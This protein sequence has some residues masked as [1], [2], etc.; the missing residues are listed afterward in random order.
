[1]AWTDTPLS[2]LAIFTSG[3]TPRKSVQ[4]YWDGDIPW[5]SASSMGKIR[6]TDSDRKLTRLGAANGTRIARA[7]TTLI[8][9]RGMSLLEE[10]RV[11]SPVRD[12]AFNQD[13]KALTALPTIDPQFLTYALL[14]K[15]PEL[16]SMVHLAGHGTGVLSTD[17]LKALRIR[18]PGIREQRR[19]A[20]VLGV[21]DD[22]I[23]TDLSLATAADACA[24]AQWHRLN[25]QSTAQAELAS[26]ADVVLGGTP[27]RADPTMWGGEIPWINSGE[28]N[29]F[30][31]LHPTERITQK[32]LER[33][34]TKLMPEGTTIVAITGATLGQVSR[35]EI[36]ACGNQS[37]V[38]VYCRQ[39][40]ALNDHL[41]FTVRNSV[42]KLIASATGG[43]QQHIN[44]RNVEELLLSVPDQ[45]ALQDW[46]RTT[47]PLLDATSQLLMEADRLAQTRDELL[48]L[49][50]SG[51][52][53]VDEA[54]EA[55]PG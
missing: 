49:L 30:R 10:I 16:L 20:G 24:E 40:P 12:V 4:D 39:N 23:D 6:I 54:W 50:M 46:H 3:G 52:I 29:K 19:I 41:Y 9:V 22:L 36:P 25:S 2:E 37:L 47:G 28:A 18:H 45:P 27:S 43:A 51:R 44:K 48:P 15:R 1:M 17:R 7:G 42:Q 55:V 33:S 5:I 38:G 34:S 14:A 21:F 35:L 11:G 8:L 32:G 26:L 53:A 13:V 31:V